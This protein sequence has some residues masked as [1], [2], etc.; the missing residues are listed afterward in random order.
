MAG[1]SLGNVV[2]AIGIIIEIHC[3]NALEHSKILMD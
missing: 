1:D 2:K 3:D